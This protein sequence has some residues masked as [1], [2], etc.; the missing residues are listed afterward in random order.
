MHD[1]YGYDLDIPYL[2]EGKDGLT[3]R[4]TDRKLLG[5]RHHFIRL[6]LYPMVTPSPERRHY[7][8]WDL[9]L[10]HIASEETALEFDLQDG[11]IRFC[12]QRGKEIEIKPGMTSGFKEQG[13]VTFNVSLWKTSLVRSQLVSART[14]L[15]ALTG[16]D[17][18]LPLRHIDVPV[19]T[20]CNL[21]CIMCPGRSYTD[22]T[23]ADVSEEVFRPSLDAAPMAVQI[24]TSWF[25]EPL[26]NEN[27]YS[28]IARLKERVGPECEVG[29]PTNGTLLNER[30][31]ARLL[32]TGVDF[33]V[34][35]L[36]GASRE[37]FEGIR[38]GVNFDTVIRSI[39]NCVKY[40]NTSGSKK[41]RLS[42]HCVIMDANLHEIPQYVNLAADLG[43]DGVSFAYRIDSESGMFQTYDKQVIGPLFEKARELAD[44]RGMPLAL[45]ALQRSEVRRCYFMQQATISISGDVVPCCGMASVPRTMV[46]F[47]NVTKQPLIDIWNSPKYVTFRRRVL[48]GDFPEECMGCD[49]NRGLWL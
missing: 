29:L 38:L 5:S 13:Y 36:D 12:G 43:V 49:Y 34:F 14:Y 19:T 24:V 17:K 39:R 27:I 48:A 9:P 21:K 2:L 32:D 47:G 46:T 28:M 41:P 44:A 40:R 3:L 23:E 18:I 10:R 31:A 45:P 16:E 33:L 7:G 15:T 11:T 6:D 37:T 25:G 4:I 20:R 30:N 26:L 8:W 35:S 22:A 42:C 1:D